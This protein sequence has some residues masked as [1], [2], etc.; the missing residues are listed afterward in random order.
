MGALFIDIVLIGVIVSILDSPGEIWV[1]ALAG[2]GA[3]MWKIKGT[4]IGGLVCGLKLVRRDGAEINWDFI[5]AAMA[6][7]ADIA[8]I[9]LQDV[10]GLG[11]EARMNIPASE[12]GNW[13][14]RYREGALTG[15]SS[16]RLK[17]MA[18]LYGRNVDA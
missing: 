13:G 15:E 10:L 3:L 6:S 4:T 5:R 16:A 12:Q 8:I 7:V 9:Q 11:S 1:V 2:Y 17:E 18:A 14:W